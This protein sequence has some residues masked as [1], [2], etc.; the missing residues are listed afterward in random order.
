M[1]R[2]GW[3]R[4]RGGGGGGEKEEG[5]EREEVGGRVRRR[6]RKGRWWRWRRK[7]RRGRKA[8]LLRSIGAQELDHGL[9]NT[10]L[11]GTGLRISEVVLQHNVVTYEGEVCRPGQTKVPAHCPL[12]TADSSQGVAP[13]A[14]TQRLAEVDVHNGPPGAGCL[15]APRGLDKWREVKLVPLRTDVD[16]LPCPERRWAGQ[17]G[18]DLHQV[19]AVAH[20]GHASHGRHVGKTVA[21]EEE[22]RIAVG[23]GSFA[24]SGTVII[25][26]LERPV[27]VTEGVAVLA[28]RLALCATQ[29][30][31]ASVGV[32]AVGAIQRATD[33]NL[34]RETL[35]RAVV[36]D[37][38]DGGEVEHEPCTLLGHG[39]VVAHGCSR[40]ARGSRHPVELVGPTGQCSHVDGNGGEVPRLAD[41]AHDH[42]TLAAVLGLDRKDVAVHRCD[43]GGVP[44]VKAAEGYGR[45]VE[46]YL[47]DTALGTG[48]RG[49][50]VLTVLDRRVPLLGHFQLPAR[51]QHVAGRLG[52]VVNGNPV[53][54]CVEREGHEAVGAVAD[55]KVAE[56]TRAARAASQRRDPLKLVVAV[57]LGQKRYRVVNRVFH[58]LRAHKIDDRGPLVV[59]LARV[60]SR[61]G[62]GEG[63]VGIAQLPRR[64]PKRPTDTTRI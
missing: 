64:L 5:E 28:R 48:G 39:A 40:G 59:T 58:R 34:V 44:E 6:E 29:L 51:V 12:H 32:C 24:A 10:A 57:V 63:P 23:V 14:A 11:P 50:A 56:V 49:L 42:G 3:A 9:D 60:S 31:D 1:F 13:R 4:K 15:P 36:R 33:C 54:S 41:V 52:F 26:Q 30:T 27:N 47:A 46:R 53:L 62:E 20:L 2:V 55:L 21:V 43:G 7:E 16:A 17:L 61:V 18:G 25:H 38:R 19:L 22:C 35:V 8:H 45:T 37:R